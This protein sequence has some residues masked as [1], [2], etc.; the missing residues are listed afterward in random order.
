MRFQTEHKLLDTF[1][2]SSLTDIVLL[3]LI[4]FLLSSTF[5]MQP[6][7]NVDLAEAESSEEVTGRNI[8][9]TITKDFQYYL[10]DRPMTVEELG[11]NLNALAK[12]RPGN[13]VIIRA[14]KDLV[15]DKLVHVWD[16]CLQVGL[17]KI[18]LATEPIHE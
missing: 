6:G 17:T 10:N 5:I 8:T 7:I 11:M 16:I 14:D 12:E 3:L 1:S 18:K 13:M 2:F 9:I 4:F 15:V